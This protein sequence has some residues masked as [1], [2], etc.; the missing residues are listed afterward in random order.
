MQSW[1]ME[2]MSQAEKVVVVVTSLRT[3][4][5]QAPELIV[6]KLP[7]SD[8]PTIPVQLA[9]RRRLTGGKCERVGA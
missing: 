8:I 3:V 7:G 4:A 1:A 5:V 2:L 6:A 9:A